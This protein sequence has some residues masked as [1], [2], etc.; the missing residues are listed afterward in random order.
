MELSK[1][2]MNWIKTEIESVVDSHRTDGK[3]D[4][5]TFDPKNFSVGDLMEIKVLLM[6]QLYEKVKGVN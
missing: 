1:E 6:K 4:E 5:I 2:E 3:Q